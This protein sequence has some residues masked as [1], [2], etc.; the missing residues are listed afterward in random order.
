MEEKQENPEL[1][2]V[3]LFMNYVDQ[4]E[5]LG[6]DVRI[7]ANCTVML[8]DTEGPILLKGEKWLGMSEIKAILQFAEKWAREQTSRQLRQNPFWN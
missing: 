4:L 2:D 5:E 3:E 7:G 6:F 1:E 8:S